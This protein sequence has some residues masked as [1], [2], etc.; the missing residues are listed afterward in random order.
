MENKGK[1]N[2]EKTEETVKIM[3]DKYIQN[4]L[5]KEMKLDPY[6]F[7]HLIKEDIH[8]ISYMESL[9]FV[10]EEYLK[11]KKKTIAQYC[12]DIL[13]KLK[14]IYVEILE[15]ILPQNDAITILFVSILSG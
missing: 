5:E 1:L 2:I 8:F 9:L 10:R 13:I 6:E 7:L 15:K 3:V 11:D 14:D 4:E 12:V